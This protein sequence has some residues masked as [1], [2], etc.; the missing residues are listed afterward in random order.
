MPGGGKRDESRIRD[1]GVGARV[2]EFDRSDTLAIGDK[3][4]PS[5]GRADTRIRV[6]AGIAAGGGGVAAC[7]R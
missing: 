5:E 7:V 4:V 6:G 2:L 3:H 1:A